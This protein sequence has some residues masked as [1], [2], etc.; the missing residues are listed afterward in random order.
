MIG[1]LAVKAEEEMRKISDFVK[2]RSRELNKR[3]DEPERKGAPCSRETDNGANK[4]ADW[5]KQGGGN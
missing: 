4:M 3:V 2:V 5:E 1:E